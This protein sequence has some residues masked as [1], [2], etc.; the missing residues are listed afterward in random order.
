MS[1]QVFDRW[2]PVGMGGFFGLGHQTWGL[3]RNNNGSVNFTPDSSGEFVQYRNDSGAN[4]DSVNHV[5]W[6]QRTG[7]VYFMNPDTHQYTLMDG[8]G[9]DMSGGIFQYASDDQL[10]KA[11]DAIVGQLALDR[12]AKTQQAR[13]E[14]LEQATSDNYGLNT[15]AIPNA[16][17]IDE[18]QKTE[19]NKRKAEANKQLQALMTN[20]TDSD[21]ST[22]NSTVYYKY[23]PDEIDLKYYLHNLGTNLQGYLNSQNWTSAQKDAF[24]QAYNTYKEELT[25]QLNNKTSR[26]S[27]DDAGTLIDADGILGNTGGV[28]MDELG[29]TYNSIDEIE[30]KELRKTATTFSANQEVM[31]YLNTV[32]QAIV[33][34][35]KTK[36]SSGDSG[37]FDLNKNGFVNF[38]QNKAN[39]GGGKIDLDPFLQLDPVSPTGK[40]ERT[41]RLKYLSFELNKYINKINKSSL[42]FSNTAFKTKENYINKVRQAINNLNNG[43]DSTDA[44]TL[45]AI[46]ITPDFYDTFLSEEAKPLMTDA[47]AEAELAKKKEDDASNYIAKVKNIYDTEVGRRHL[48]TKERGIK[49]I[50]DARY[51]PGTEGSGQS[52]AYALKTFGY[53]VGNATQLSASADQVWSAV[54]EALYSGSNV[55]ATPNGQKSLEEVL[56]VILPS[57]VGDEE[58]FKTD[59]KSGIKI[60][61]DP[62]FNMATGAILCWNGNTLYFDFIGNHKG[63]ANITWSNLKK[64]FEESYGKT[65]KTPKYTF[66]KQGGVLKKLQEGGSTPQIDEA[67]LA[68]I[69]QMQQAAATSEGESTP[70]SVVEETPTVG[71]QRKAGQS[72]GEALAEAVYGKRTA[73]AKSKGM[74]YDQY[75]KKQRK[76]S[77]VP[78][79]YNEDNGVWKTEDY[80]RLGAIAADIASIFL[81]PISGAVAN[82]VSTATNFMAD[83]ADGSVTTGEMWKNLAMNLGMDALS[84]VPVVGDAAGTGGKLL[85]SAKAIAPKLAYALTA[86]GILGTLKNGANIMESLGKLTSD[87]KLTVGDWQ[88]IAQAI[89]AFAGVS[90]GVKA[91]VAKRIS[92]KRAKVDDAIGVGLKK[93]GSDAPA[94]DYIFRG[95]QAQ[96]LKK[97]IAEG[98]VAKVNAKLHEFEGFSNYNIN[99]NL[100][101]KPIDL[102]LPVGRKLGDDGKKHWGFQQPTTIARKMDYFEIYDKSKLQGGYWTKNKLN[103]NR[104]DA[105]AEEFKFGEGDLITKTE[106]E[107]LK[108][109][110]IDALAA[111]AKAATEKRTRL[112]DENKKLIEGVKDEN[113]N[114]VTKGQKDL[115]AEAQTKVN[116]A[117]ADVA[118]KKKIIDDIVAKGHNKGYR[119]L[120]KRVFDITDSK[121]FNNK[122]KDLADAIRNKQG[123]ISV[124]D[125]II[126]GKKKKMDVAAKAGN[127]RRAK[128]LDTEIQK[129]EKQRE[130]LVNKKSELENIQTELTSWE[131]DYNS[132]SAKNSEYL[133]AKTIEDQFKAELVNYNKDLAKLQ[134]RYDALNDVN[135]KTSATQ[136]LY[137]KIGNDPFKITYGTGKT[138]EI[139]NAD[140]RSILDKMNLL[141][142]G[143]RLQF[144]QD[145]DNV[146][147]N[148]TKS[149]VTYNEN[150]FPN[151]VDWWNDFI[152]NTIQKE[153]GSWTRTGDISDE[154]K[155]VYD[156]ISIDNYEQY[157]KLQN[158]LYCVVFAKGSKNPNSGYGSKLKSDP[159]AT[160]LQREFNRLA[161][162]LN[163]RI[164]RMP[165][166]TV[167][168][169]N[170][171]DNAK[172]KWGADSYAGTQTWLRH[173]GAD[174]GVVSI[175]NDLG[176]LQNNGIEAY[177]NNETG[178]VNFRPINSPNSTPTTST[179]TDIQKLSLQPSGFRGA[180]GKGRKSTKG[181]F[182]LGNLKLLTP[183]LLGL[184]R[185][186]LVDQADRKAAKTKIAAIHPY[187]QRPLVDNIYVQSDLPTEA[188]GRRQA[189]SIMSTAF[190]PMTADAGK[191]MAYIKDAHKQGSDY[192]REAFTSS[193]KTLREFA[194]KDLAQRMANHK[195]EH[196]VGESN[197]L[198][199]QQA[200]SDKADVWQAYKTKQANNLDSLLYS[201]QYDLATEEASKKAYKDAVYASRIKDAVKYNPNKYGADLSSTELAAY[202][203]ALTADS[204]ESLSDAEKTN[205][206]SAAG[207]V[208]QIQSRLLAKY[209][210]VD[211]TPYD[212]DALRRPKATGSNYVVRLSSLA[213]KGG[214]LAKNGAKV[215]NAKAKLRIKNADRLQ[216]SIEKKIDSLNKQLDRISKSMYGL[217][218]LELVK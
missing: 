8:T 44:A 160:T 51:Q 28:V 121:K 103:T 63:E 42:D 67:T 179:G 130:K 82:G 53:A 108:N 183:D 22:E 212:E 19:Y 168:G 133:Q 132:L 166:G 195:Q 61:N 39:P 100:S 74:T 73:A 57:H 79:L 23:G 131:A 88:N 94:Q 12:Q 217:P 143:G 205:Y 155:A 191:Q 3:K 149:N 145:G 137:N 181:K 136:A 31:N 48:I 196:L 175:L 207:K 68:A 170:T 21:D 138:V 174:N 117:V 123:E 208:A 167:P 85:K 142:K 112:R 15:I 147:L 153:D 125:G 43:W 204:L 129:Y 24:K 114:I 156:K 18:A 187:L 211:S 197:R 210:G 146:N 52:I 84:I 7:E 214:V 150:D 139:S 203:K 202:N 122:K 35:G 92:K 38:W 83:W 120:G 75:N 62:A 98:D 105:V 189:A 151:G 37:V 157:N 111:D 97:L 80:A 17:T 106:L 161:P 9:L 49:V 26:F 158:E 4:K 13:E 86:Y 116:G 95:K 218:K 78:D 55:V 11:S 169:A 66:D 91:G 46:G 69:Q 60:Y 141:K 107:T 54:L 192:M 6:N 87:E 104:Q 159:N 77:G 173:L 25:N 190:R 152:A 154:A 1:S 119:V 47:E 16:E 188:L 45:Q 71:F 115:V 50:K 96:E 81:D 126:D 89:T 185:Y 216:K 194:M 113:G 72:V 101:T 65:G 59:E 215:A 177:Y 10:D 213:K 20:D 148:N 90:G 27:T 76:P 118:A 172:H 64:K 209:Q 180:L 5:F 182:D 144:L 124:I 29:N 93:E 201:K 193:S 33:G 127:E 110:Q 2:D 165:F 178:M 14:A 34:A 198:S 40:R 162:E 128:A 36:K 200:I 140:L 41:N 99:T 135:T 163:K 32:G 134:T 109:Q 102:H 176:I 206:M 56:K 199:S 58:E 164:D 70:T 30:D 171:S 184:A 186:Y